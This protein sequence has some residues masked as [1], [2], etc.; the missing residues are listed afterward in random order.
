M[1]A[2]GPEQLDASDMRLSRD[3][4]RSPRLL[5]AGV[6]RKRRVVVGR[7]QITP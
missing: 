4:F 6:S 5:V 1:M 2:K 3:V 7:L